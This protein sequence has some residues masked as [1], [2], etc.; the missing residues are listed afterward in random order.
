[1]WHLLRAATERNRVLRE[2]GLAE[3]S[4]RMLAHGSHMHMH[5]QSAAQEEQ[6]AVTLPSVAGLLNNMPTSQPTYKTLTLTDK[7]GVTLRAEVPP[8]QFDSALTSV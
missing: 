2:G 7:H 3:T 6:N 5:S 8:P 1:M 4:R